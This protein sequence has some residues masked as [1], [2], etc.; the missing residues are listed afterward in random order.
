MR[1]AW[2]ERG[3][4]NRQVFQFVGKAKDLKAVLIALKGSGAVEKL[5]SC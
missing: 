1:I 4:G 5:S 3:K 2:D